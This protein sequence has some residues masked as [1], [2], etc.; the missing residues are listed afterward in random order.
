MLNRKVL[1]PCQNAMREEVDIKSPRREFR[2][3]GST[4]KKVRSCTKNPLS[5]EKSL[6]GMSDEPGQVS[7]LRIMTSKLD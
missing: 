3:C 4:T 1:R 5:W 6:A 7:R 2:N